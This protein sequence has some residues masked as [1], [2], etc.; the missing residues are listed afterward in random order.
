MVKNLGKE[1]IKISELVGSLL[2][3]LSKLQKELTRYKR[4]EDMEIDYGKLVDEID[5]WRESN[6]DKRSFLEMIKGIA[7]L[8]KAKD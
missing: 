5:K 6:T 2:E 3:E 7:G 4:F 8:I 1:D